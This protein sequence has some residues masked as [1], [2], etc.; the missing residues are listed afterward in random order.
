[1]YSSDSEIAVDFAPQPP[2][3]S[4][5]PGNSLIQE[6]LKRMIASRAFSGSLR[7]SALLKFLVEEAVADRADGLKEQVI[8][9]EVYGKGSEFDPSNHS[10]VRVDVRRL[11]DKIREYYESVGAADR[12]RIEIPKGTYCPRF[13]DLHQYAQKSFK[14]QEAPSLAVLPFENLSGD[15]EE[16]YFADGV[17]DDLITELAKLGALRVISRSS[18]MVYKAVRKRIPELARELDVT[19]VV[20]GTVLRQSGRVRINCQLIQAVPEAHVWADSYD[21]DGLDVVQLQSEIARAL[22]DQIPG[23]SRGGGQYSGRRTINTQA[24]DAYLRGRYHWNRLTPQDLH[25]SLEYF[26]AAL[27]HDPGYPPAYAGLADAYLWLGVQNL[28]PHAEC[29]LKARAAAEK[30]LE[31]DRSNA[32]AWNTLGCV[33][34]Y[35]WEWE[36]AERFFQRALELNPNSA[37]AHMSYGSFLAHL[38]RFEEAI[39]EN[40]LAHNL[41][42][43]AI[44]ID[45]EYGMI[46]I[47]SRRF[48]EAVRHLRRMIRSDPGYFLAHF[49]LG[50]AYIYQG[51]FSQAVEALE[52]AIRIA[53]LPDFLA[54][55]AHAH[56]RAKHEAKARQLLEQLGG[57]ARNDDAPAFLLAVAMLGF[58]DRDRAMEY[59]ETAYQQRD[60]L[61]RLI[62]VEPGFDELRADPRFIDLLKRM[63]FPESIRT[64]VSSIS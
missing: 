11:R 3:R 19:H 35:A 52:T 36:A 8:A 60:W 42:P 9:L 61:V 53:P 44:N 39:R 55:L 29:Y 7:L 25:K 12:V 16:E 64:A 1:V 32:D 50:R 45:G 18:A 28:I 59:L 13:V 54:V 21:R 26:Q 27:A 49:H 46:L 48:E 15:S 62:G 6:Q 43:L 24:H 37:L 10:A 20:T 30:A 34:G 51:R 41:D 40:R 17:T 47:E 5:S 57:L 38:G 63:A 31:I 58:G 56:A 22:V 14:G 4:S 33:A 2:E 23:A